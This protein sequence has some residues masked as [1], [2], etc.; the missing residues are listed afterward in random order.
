MSISACRIISADDLSCSS[1]S[2]DTD[3]DASSVI[4][5]PPFSPIT[6]EDD[7]S[8]P[9]SELETD[10]MSSEEDEPGTATFPLCG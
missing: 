3:S 8:S 10:E 5:A 7:L 6:S 9:A 2:S 4:I 1:S